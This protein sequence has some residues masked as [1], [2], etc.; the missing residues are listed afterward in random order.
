MARVGS[1]ALLGVV[2]VGPP[3]AS[4]AAAAQNILEGLLEL[5]A[6]AGVDHGVDAAVE[7]AQPKAH[8]EHRVRRLVRW[9]E[10][11]LEKKETKKIYIN[12]MF[13]RLVL[14]YFNPFPNSKLCFCGY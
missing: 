1:T 7:I 3:P 5:L 8:F 10:G 2:E 12:V 14:Q 6:E 13:H 11:P 9:E 4:E